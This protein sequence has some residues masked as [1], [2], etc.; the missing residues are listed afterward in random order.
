MET[1]K[2]EW[3]ISGREGE[4]EQEKQIKIAGGRA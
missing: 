1:G 2:T 4:R 3:G